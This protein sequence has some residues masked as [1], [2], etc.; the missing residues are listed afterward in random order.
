M[1]EEKGGKRG[2]FKK[3]RR[4][5][6]KIYSDMKFLCKYIEM[7]PEEASLDTSDHNV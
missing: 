5:S 2:V 6:E 4:H 1:E 3:K 7:K